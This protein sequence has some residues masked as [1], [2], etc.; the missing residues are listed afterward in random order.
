MTSDLEATTDDLYNAI[1]ALWLD[2]QGAT[3]DDLPTGGFGQRAA[4][5]VHDSQVAEATG[6]ELGAVREYLDNAN[7]VKLVV[8]H[9]GETRVIKGML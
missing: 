3:G 8:E 9:D 5:S 4:A 7:G 1:R 6:L 2:A